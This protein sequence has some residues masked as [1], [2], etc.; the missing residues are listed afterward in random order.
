MGLISDHLSDDSMRGMYSQDHVAEA[1][2]LANL[3]ATARVRKYAKGNGGAPNETAD[4]IERRLTKATNELR[5]Y[6]ERTLS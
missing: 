5:T 3:M 6:L 1:M 2:R 4:Q